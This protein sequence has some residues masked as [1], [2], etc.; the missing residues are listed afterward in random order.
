[1]R[2]HPW[3]NIKPASLPNL[4]NS[5]VIPLAPGALLLFSPFIAI[6]TLPNVGSTMSS[7]EPKHWNKVGVNLD[8]REVQE[9]VIALRAL[10]L[11][12]V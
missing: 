10:L 4:R 5:V 1:L 7:H 11:W 3:R 9:G 2:I 12:A 8:A 6:T